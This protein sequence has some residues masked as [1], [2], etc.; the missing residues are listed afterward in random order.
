MESRQEFMKIIQRSGRE[1]FQYLQKLFAHC[2][3]YVI[4]N[5]RYVKIPKDHTLIQAGTACSHIYVLLR[6][7]LSG[8][9]F[10]RVGN[11]YNF[12]GFA[13]AE[14]IGD[15]EVFGDFKEYRVSV[16]SITECELLSISAG[17][18]LKWMRGDID[19]LFM[20]TQRL[21]HTLTEQ[22]S[23][24]RKFRFLP[25][26]DRLILYLVE[27]YESV[28]ERAFC[29]IRKTQSEIAGRVGFTVRTVQ[30]TVHNLEKEGFITTEAGKV[31]IDK[32]QYQKLKE[33]AKE[34]LIG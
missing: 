3:D 25:C 8:L 2:P 22:T 19:A 18:Y 14:V 32:E 29:K 1:Q 13:R 23:E 16:R 9:D 24:E 6:G 27:M 26:K 10:Q 11:V 4:E 21:M 17:V 5:M 12:T 33:Y 20:R 28:P 7:K 34:H 30:R 15:Y 31:C